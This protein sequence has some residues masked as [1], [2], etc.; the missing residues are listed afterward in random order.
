MIF[1]PFFRFI[2]TSLLSYIL[3][4]LLALFSDKIRKLTV[5]ATLYII[6]Y[7]CYLFLNLK[8][9]G[10]HETVMKQKIWGKKSAWKESQDSFISTCDSFFFYEIVQHDSDFFICNSSMWFI[11]ILLHDSFFFFFFYTIHPHDSFI[12]TFYTHGSFFYIRFNEF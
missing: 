12:S 11:A 5:L 10:R 8:I 3:D 1:S 7:L 9:L 4:F 6:K 2:Y